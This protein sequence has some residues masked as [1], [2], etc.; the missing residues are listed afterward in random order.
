MMDTESEAS[1]EDAFKLGKPEKTAAGKNEEES[2]ESSP[3]GEDSVPSPKSAAK[4]KRVSSNSGS[5]AGQPKKPKRKLVFII[6]LSID[7][8]A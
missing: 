7:F 3:E 1:S 4:R 8:I 6:G 5:E 2:A